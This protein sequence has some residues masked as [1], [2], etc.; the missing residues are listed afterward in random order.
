PRL[1]RVNINSYFRG[2][3]DRRIKKFSCAKILEHCNMKFALSLYTLAFLTSL[4]CADVPP[5]EL[6]EAPVQL[7]ASSSSELFNSTGLRSDSECLAVC[8]SHTNTGPSGSVQQLSINATGCYLIEASGAWGG[9]STS[10]GKLGGKGALAKGNFSLTLDTTLS[11]LV[12][13]AGAEP[14][15][16]YGGAGGGGGSFVFINSSPKQLLVAA[17]GGGGATRYFDGRPGQSGVNGTDATQSSSGKPSFDHGGANGAAGYNSPQEVDSKATHGGCGSGWN[18]KA[19]NVRRGNNDG[20]RGGWL[21]D[22]SGGGGGAGGTYNGGGSGAG[23][24]GFGGG[25]GGGCGGSG[26]TCDSACSGPCKSSGGGGGGYSGGGAGVNEGQA[27]GGG[28][29]YCSGVGCSSVTGGSVNSANPHGLVTATANCPST[30]KKDTSVQFALPDNEKQQKSAGGGPEKFN[31]P[32]TA[33]EATTAAALPVAMDGL[34]IRRSPHPGSP[35]WLAKLNTGYNQRARQGFV[36]WFTGR[37]KPTQFG[38]YSTGAKHMQYGLGMAPRSA[39]ARPGHRHQTVRIRRVHR[40]AC[41]AGAAGTGAVGA[42]AATS[43]VAVDAGSAA[44][45]AAAA[46]ARGFALAFAGA[47][48]LDG[49]GAA[50]T[51]SAAAEA[52]GARAAFSSSSASAFGAVKNPAASF[53]VVA[54]QSGVGGLATPARAAAAVPGQVLDITRLVVAS[55]SVGTAVVEARPELL[56]AAVDE[57]EAAAASAGTASL[58]IGLCARLANKDAQSCVQSQAE[59]ALGQCAF[60]AQLAAFGVVAAPGSGGLDELGSQSP[61]H[62]SLLRL[63]AQRIVVHQQLL[64]E[65]GRWNEGGC[66]TVTRPTD[67]EALG[68]GAQ[69]GGVEKLAARGGVEL[70]RGLRELEWRHVGCEQHSVMGGMMSSSHLSSVVVN[71]W[72]SAHR[73]KHMAST[74]TG[75]RM[76]MAEIAFTT[77]SRTRQS[78][79]YFC[80]MKKSPTRCTNCTPRRLEMP[81]NRNTPY[82]TGMGMCLSTGVRKTDRP[83]SRKIR[84]PRRREGLRDVQFRSLQAY[85]QVQT[86][87]GNN[88]YHHSEIA[89]DHT[90]SVRKEWRSSHQFESIADHKCANS[91]Q[92]GEEEY[93]WYGEL[94]AP[95]ANPLAQLG[96]AQL[97]GHIVED[98]IRHERGHAPAHLVKVGTLSRRSQQHVDEPGRH[99]N[100]GEI[101]QHNGSFQSNKRRHRMV[102]KVGTANQDVGSLSSW[103][104]FLHEVL[105]EPVAAGGRKNRMHFRF[106]RPVLVVILIAAEGGHVH[107]NVHGLAAAYAAAAA[108]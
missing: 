96:G 90:D 8:R 101:A 83:M 10:S 25:G 70:D 75:N 29:S 60:A 32:R 16:H 77:Q 87:H 99:W 36:Y 31:R 3:Q 47:A 104:N 27:G 5:F 85:Q 108:A 48:A 15:D 100:L 105:V 30:S 97:V 98:L 102:E 17:G 58:V 95:A 56:R 40:A 39:A 82:S 61:V 73:T 71:K 84:K 80:G 2:T 62:A 69:A 13:Q 64:T 37:P 43:L 63:L 88:R 20:E 106:V 12:G 66:Q 91:Q 46:A 49:T 34:R 55:S 103:R 81:M 11:I 107:S 22:S 42:A 92:A 7:N 54:A 1:L 79:W 24:G 26:S 23:T 78:G 50:A 6:T 86:S 89:N 9:N 74:M 14:N 35:S 76:E 21:F 57:H 72:F 44:A 38:R 33:A 94:A 19:D 68:V 41:D 28:G 53:T 65:A 45:V 51:A 4:A 93:V 67:G 18:G 52:S 59:V